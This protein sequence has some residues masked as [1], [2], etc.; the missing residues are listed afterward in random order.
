MR[1]RDK[2]SLIGGVVIIIFTAT[3]ATAFMWPVPQTDSPRSIHVIPQDYKI[4][5]K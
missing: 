5:S 2:H 3:L 4:S 1:E